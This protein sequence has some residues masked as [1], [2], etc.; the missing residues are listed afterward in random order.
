MKL[1]NIFELWERDSII[2]R[3]ELD[4]ESLNASNLISL[5]LGKKQKSVSL[6]R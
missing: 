6:S 3:E 2:N 4:R 5:S 1:E